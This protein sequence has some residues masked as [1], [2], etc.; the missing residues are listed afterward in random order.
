MKM[1]NFIKLTLATTDQKPIYM[2]M[3]VVESIMHRINP[4]G[5]LIDF[6][7]SESCVNVVETP[8]EIM[9]LL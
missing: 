2:N 4:V 1:S 6:I 8:E 3:D 5:S 9:A 7:G